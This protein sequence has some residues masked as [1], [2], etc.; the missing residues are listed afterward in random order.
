MNFIKIIVEGIIFLIGL[1]GLSSRSKKEIVPTDGAP[2]IWY[3]NKSLDG[4][5]F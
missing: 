1:F 5:F 4:Y 2:F 3:D